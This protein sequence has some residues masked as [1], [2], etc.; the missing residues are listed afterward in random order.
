MKRQLDLFPK[1]EIDATLPTATSL[2]GGKSSA[3]MALHYPTDVYLFAPVLT[4]DPACIIQDRS[5]RQ[6][7]QAKVPSFN[8][9]DGG[10][11]E[12]DQTLF[13]LRKLEQELG[14]EIAWVAAPFTYDQLIAGDIETAIARA[15]GRSST[16]SAMLPNSRLRFCTE[17]LKVY[18]IAWWLYLN[19]NDAPWVVHI[20]FRADEPRRVQ[21]W[22][23]DRTDM[24]LHCD[25]EGRRK[26]QHRHTLLDYRLATFPMFQDGIDHL[27]VIKFWKDKG[28]EFPA[29]SN[30]D[31]CF[32]H[33]KPEM[34]EQHE[35][36]G[37]RAKWWM[38][39]E[40]TAGA[41]FGDD[42]LAEIIYGKAKGETELLSCLCTD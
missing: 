24:T 26:W 40:E 30:C 35:Q 39:M 27:D 9:D 20:G 4:N 41:T 42:P 10:C 25:I 11:R 23:C 18:P 6:Y 12:L 22:K 3:Y 28:W 14:Q 33:R 8:W 37:D 36:H 17:S 5:L 34:L 19:G 2:S 29:V 32:F 16:K 15:F 13:N 21:T 38:E 1:P 7:C 31:F